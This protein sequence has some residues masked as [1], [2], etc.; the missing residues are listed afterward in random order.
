MD[1]DAIVELWIVALVVVVNTFTLCGDLERKAE[2]A[3]ESLEA[4]RSSGSAR[5]LAFVLRKA[6]DGDHTNRS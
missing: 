5:S 6:N 1:G 2:P 3:P 4:S